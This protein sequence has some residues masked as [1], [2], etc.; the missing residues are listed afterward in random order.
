[1]TKILIAGDYCPQNETAT[2]LD[3]KKYDKVFSDFTDL[4]KSCDFNVVNLECPVVDDGST[5][6]NLKKGVLLKCNLSAIEALKIT[7]FNLVTLAN[8]HFLDWGN[9][10]VN[11]TINAC[12][13]FEIGY[14]GGGEDIHAAKQVFYKNIN[15]KTF[16]FLNFCENEF[17]I[18]TNSNSGSNPLNPVDNF[19][20]IKNAKS[21][22]DFVIV[23]VH[24]GHEHY[25]LPSPRMKETYRFF[26]DAGANAVI[27]HHTHCY[28]GNEIYKGFPIIYGVGNFLFNSKFKEKDTFNEGYVAVIEFQTNGVFYKEVPLVQCKDSSGVRFMTSEEKLKFRAKIKEL[29]T[30]ISDDTLLKAEFEKL[31][32]NVSAYYLSCFEPYSSRIGLGLFSRKLLPSFL[33][34]NKILTLHNKIN[35]ES[36]RDIVLS[37]FGKKIEKFKY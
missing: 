20:Q 14:I 18:A 29:N 21:K 36:H 23:I 19:Y 12:R 7:G 32:S 26:I 33:S 31:A 11:D 2:L 37:N 6:N 24:G 4:L 22:S 27:G 8:N 10:G 17:S 5:A 1:M 35:C 28:S 30:I 16:A 34:K 13:K 9:K 25:Q 3:E 15:N